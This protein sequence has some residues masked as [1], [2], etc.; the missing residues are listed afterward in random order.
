MRAM[1]WAASLL[2]AIAALSWQP[3][4]AEPEITIAATSGVPAASTYI[5]LEK[6][7]FR[8]AGLAVTVEEFESAGA[9]IPLLASNRIQIEQGGIS[10]GFFNAVARGLPVTLALDSGSSPINQDLLLRPDL[11]DRIKTIADLRGHIVSVVGPGSSPI[12]A[13][14]KLLDS[15]GLS[16]SDVEIKYLPFVELGPAFANR[17]IDAALAVPPFGDLLVENGFAVRWLSPD[18]MIR[19]TPMSIIGYMVNTDWAAQHRAAAERLFLALAKAGRDYCQAYHHGPGRDAIIDILMKHRALTD[20]ALLERMKWQARNPDG[21][22]NL[23]SLVDLQDWYFRNGMIDA[24]AP[25]ER[26]TDPRYAE[27]VATELGPFELVN[28]ESKLEGCR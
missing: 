20:R 14:G 11:S 6:G 13:V 12:Y 17:A 2:A 5:A 1:D 18:K 28:A 23:A 15:A 27:A 24:K 22:F 25:P 21:R 16:L 8:D 4:S 3:A 26:L 9:M 19:P 10:A 7:Y